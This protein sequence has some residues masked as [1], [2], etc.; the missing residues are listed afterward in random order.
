MIRLLISDLHLAKERPAVTRAFFRFMEQEAVH[1]DELYILGDL[2]EAWIGDDDPG[3]LAR[4]VVAGL[5]KL[6]DSGTRVYFIH[7]NRDFLIGRRFARQTGCTLLPSYHCITSG[8]QK[9]LLC[10]GDTLCTE[11][12]AYQRYRRRVRNPLVRWLLTH[13]PLDRRLKMAADWRA[14]SMAANSNKPANIMDVTPSEVERQLAAHGAAVVIHG[15]THRPGIHHHDNGD[16]V[17]LGDWDKLGWY[18][19]IEGENLDLNDFPIRREAPRKRDDSS[20]PPPPLALEMPPAPTGD[21]AP[22]P[23]ISGLTSTGS[24][25]TAPAAM[26]TEPE[27]DEDEDAPASAAPAQ[28]SLEPAPQMP[29]EGQR[30]FSAKGQHQAQVSATKRTPQPKSAPRGEEIQLSLDL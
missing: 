14:R 3:A 26:D 6:S 17:V 11:D 15:H 5:R 2:F 12:K 10:H 21:D 16:R 27:T 18:V 19:K 8:E 13:L 25:E 22:Q 24:A 29:G 9:L 30:P 4:A 7:G 23:P 1:A 28:P 20:Q